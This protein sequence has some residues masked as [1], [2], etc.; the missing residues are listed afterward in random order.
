VLVLRYVCK[1][2]GR[3]RRAYPAGV[4]AGR[5]SAALRQLSVVLYWLGLSYL[6]VRAAL[7]DLGCALSCTSI[8]RNVAD[9]HQATGWPPASSRLDLQ[10]VG[11]GVL[12]GRDGL[13]CL[14]LEQGTDAARFLV[15]E[16]APGPNAAH[17]RWRLHE[18]AGWLARAG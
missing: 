6:G 4:G 18:A 3:A 8:R 5:Q 12:R 10:S 13:I 7:A 17:L 9:A 15:A 11:G 2:C 14:R 16:I 1:R